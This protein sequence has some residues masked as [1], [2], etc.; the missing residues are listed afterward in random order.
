M[1]QTPT[2]LR[3]RKKRQTH[4]AIVRVAMDLFA[5]HG[6]EAT[7]IADIATAADIAPRTFF[8]YFP[9]KEAVVFHDF[10]AEFES[11][12]ERL[13]TRPAGE[14]AFD[15]MRDW[16]TERLPDLAL[17]GDQHRRRR[18]LIGS[19]PA[20]QAHERS[21]LA[22]FEALLAEGVAADLGVPPES[23]RAHL[24]SAAAVAALHALGSS[25]R[26]PA[27]HSTE[28]ALAVMDEA[29][30][31]LRGGLDALRRHPPI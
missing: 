12:A 28:R 24:V 27:L 4:D 30:V 18:E 21:N 9:S 23:L 1:S 10:D 11:F 20:L 3:E 22:R 19:T 2:G 15:A 5:E 7:T 6:F 25:D 26:D 16:I 13:R 14:T 17:D 29:L 31:F 8:G